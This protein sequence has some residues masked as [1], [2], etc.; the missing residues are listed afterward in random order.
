[1]DIIEINALHHKAL[2]A[3]VQLLRQIGR[4]IVEQTLRIFA[5]CDTALAGNM[6]KRPRLRIFGQ[7]SPDVT[8]RSAHAIDAGR[9]DV[10]YA[11]ISRGI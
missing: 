3:I 1:M 4:L 8:L 10:I 6:K 2:E 11:Q 9:V 5:V 7:V